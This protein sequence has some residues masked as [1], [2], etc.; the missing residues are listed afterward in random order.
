MASGNVAYSAE[1]V[2]IERRVVGSRGD[3]LALLAITGVVVIA[4]LLTNG[5]YGFH[6]DE[7]QVLSDARHLDWGFVPYP[8]F[9][10]F[11]ERIGLSLFGLSLVGLRLFSVISNATAIIFT[12]LIAR[13]LGGER[14]AQATA[15]LAVALSPLPMFEGTEF[16]YTTFDYLWWVLI[17]YF[18]IRLLETENPRWW[19]AIGA[20]LGVGFLTKYTMGFYLCGIMGGLVLTRARRYLASPWFWGGMGLGLLIC[21]PNI[22]WQVRHGFIS[23]HF[24][25]HI[26]KRDVGE[27]RADGFWR[28]Q[29][30]IC[31]NLIAAPLWIGGLIGFLR[32]RRYRM[33]AWM[34]LIPLALFAVSKGRGY[35]LGAAYPMLMAMG[36]VM[37]ER[38]VGS[39]SRGW[40]WAVEGVF[41]VL[42]IACGAY[43]S[44]IVIP[45]ASGGPLKEFALKN[46]GDLREEIGWE[47]LVQSVAGVRDALPAEQRGSVGIVVG[48]YGE[49]G[50][51]EILGPAYQLPPP[52]SGTNSAWLR[53][54]PEPPPS[55]LIVV[56]HGQ[57]YVDRMFTACRVAGHNG[58]ALGVKNE[59]SEDHP[60]IFVCGPPRLPWA[61]F[62]E[63]YQ[64]FG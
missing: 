13:E 18:V 15:A 59:E 23:L 3:T 45:W 12:G 44:G 20:T 35:Y 43:V 38:W 16:Q 11:I 56:G 33:L 36:A 37:G 24:L 55:T 46:N 47:E 52:I 10:P 25:Q 17:A 29:F 34:Y 31:T 7:L 64:A 63:A 9:T 48:N 42:I 4:H 41:F 8:P 5:R 19:L 6:R 61:D 26:H 60:D 57:K 14:L 28:D 62:W 50:A 22:V 51:V 58:N 39:M 30:M 40:R 32:D 2:N 27:G 1:N 54:Y 49:Q 53:G 21:S